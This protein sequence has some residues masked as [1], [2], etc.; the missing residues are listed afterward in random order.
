MTDEKAS[1]TVPGTV[2]EI[3]KPSA[4]SEPERANIAVTG[5]DGKRKVISIEN[6]LTDNSGHDVHLKPGEEVDVTVKAAIE[7]IRFGR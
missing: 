6:T 5:P 3:V 2:E 1:A 4:L 7:P